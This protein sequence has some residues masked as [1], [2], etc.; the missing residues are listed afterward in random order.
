MSNKIT[1]YL[2]KSESVGQ[3]DALHILLLAELRMQPAKTDYSDQYLLAGLAG[4]CFW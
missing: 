4:L 2:K 3:D 1:G